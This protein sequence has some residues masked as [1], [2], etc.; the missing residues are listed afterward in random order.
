MVEHLRRPVAALFCSMGSGKTGGTLAALREAQDSLAVCRTLIIA[1]MRVSTDTWPDEIEEWEFSRGMP[2]TVLTGLPPKKR[3]KAAMD[4][5]PVHIINVENI[6]WLV[7]FFGDDWP[8]DHVII[9]ESTRFKGHKRR[10]DPTPKEL[11]RAEKE[12]RAARRNLTRFGSMVRVRDY[13]FTIWI[14][15]ATPAPQGYIDLWSQIFLLDRGE[16]LGRTRTAFLSRFFDK[17]YMGFSYTLREGA[18]A[19]IQDRIRDICLTVD[20]KDYL[21]VREP[22]NNVIRVHLPDPVMEQYRA[23][24]KEM[25]LELADEAITV[26]TQAAL[27]NKLLQFANGAVY[28]EDKTWASVH[29]A[30]L[31]S[32]VETVESLNGEPVIVAVNFRFDKDRILKKFGRK[33]VLLDKTPG[34][35][36][37]WNDGKIPILVMHPASDAH[38]LN[39]QHGGYTMIWYGLTCNLEHYQQLCERIGPT[40]QLQS[41]YDRVVNYHHIIAADT[42]EE[43]V[44]NI[45]TRK[46]ATQAAL[47]RALKAPLPMGEG[48]SLVA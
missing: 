48:A 14:L 38:G 28:R 31:Q 46:D 25:M 20:V 1:P 6:Q 19:V 13:I 17:D 36:K 41:G 7:K 18:A 37:K 29:D 44:V 11:E 8:Y 26:E 5:C 32:L 23:L 33:A 4:G 34:L 21:D 12:K 42:R 2:F 39:L 9:D 35:Q 45:L 27:A 24:E 47:L 30:K 16:R 40:R 43:V 15:T 3:E 22:N 10:T